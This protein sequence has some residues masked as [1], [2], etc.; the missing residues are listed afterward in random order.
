MI[1]YLLAILSIS[2]IIIY[3]VGNK[4]IEPISSIV[5]QSETKDSTI[6]QQVS[7]LT[8]NLINYD[9]LD[10]DIDTV[11]RQYTFLND[12]IKNFK[13]NIGTVE[14]SLYQNELPQYQTKNPNLFFDG[15]YPSNLKL[16]FQFPPPLPGETGPKGDKGKKGPK[17]GKGQKGRIGITGGNNHC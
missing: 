9:L 14:T 13:M 7:Y 11:S 1:K 16:N 3:L 8:N 4:T 10:K 17:G 2:I 5:T 6:P 12:Q 15:S